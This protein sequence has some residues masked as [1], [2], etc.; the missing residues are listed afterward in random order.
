MKAIVVLFI[1]IFISAHAYAVDR[2]TVKA[3]KVSE[4]AIYPERSAPASIISLNESVISAQIAARVDALSVRVG[5]IVEEG[6]V[7]AQLD[8]T[9][10][11]LSRRESTAR[12]Q[13]LRTKQELAKRRLERTR[14]LTLKQSVAEEILDERESD[15]AVLGAELRG[16]K[17]EIEIK[18]TDESRCV[19]LSPFRALVIERTSSVGEFVNVGTALV[20]IM[21]IDMT[22]ISAQVSSRDTEQVRHASELYF[23]HDDIR[24]PVKLRAIVQA[25]NTETRNREVRL[26][27][28]DSNALPGASGKLLWRD[29]RAHIPG[30]LLVRR[31]GDL[32]VF[33]VEGNIAKFNSMP[34]AQAGRASATALGSDA[35]VVIEGHFSLKEAMPVD[36]VN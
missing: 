7:L 6:G 35:R 22:E 1:T 20:K 3:A 8:C 32:G 36:V 4:I 24:Y 15:Y 10:Y 27:F 31:N 17:A 9:D 12:L 13:A 28:K 5:D 33:T 16:I 18:K 2:I 11:V 29:E 23:E 14:Q 26:T 25:I 34:S 19:V 30:E 21:D